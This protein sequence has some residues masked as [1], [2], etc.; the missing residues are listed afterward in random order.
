[1][2]QPET[3]LAP[4]TIDQ[5][6]ARWHLEPLP[7]EHKDSALKEGEAERRRAGKR[8]IFATLFGLYP[9]S[10]IRIERSGAV[11]AEN[12]PNGVLQPGQNGVLV[13]SRFTQINPY[14][15][16]SQSRCAIYGAGI[17]FPCEKGDLSLISSGSTVSIPKD[18]QFL[19]ACAQHV[20]DI[21]TKAP[22]PPLSQGTHRIHPST[23]DI[24]AILAEAE[25]RPP[26]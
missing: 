4:L 7:R 16:Q 6:M 25:I 18:W 26:S 15:T 9:D 1:M 21:T 2:A 24:D 12:M 3:R 13:E 23:P 10:L 8:A 19:L 5:F 20:K 14:R 22:P 17:A 11:R